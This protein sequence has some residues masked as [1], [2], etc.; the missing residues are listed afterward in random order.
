MSIM[1]PTIFALG[2]RGLGDDDRKLGS[3]FLVMAIIGGAILTAAM[4]AVS[5]AAGI[6]RAMGVPIVS[7]GWYWLLR[8]FRVNQP[9]TVEKK[10]AEANSLVGEY[11][12]ARHR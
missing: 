9:L 10:R 4:G 3:S 7:L 2:L 11:R 12:T 6:H 1:F 5:D 8:C